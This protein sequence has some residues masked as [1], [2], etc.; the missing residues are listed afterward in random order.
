MGQVRPIGRV[1]D[2]S[3]VPPKAKML[4]RYSECSKRADKRRDRLGFGLFLK[5]VPQVLTF[6]PALCSLSVSRIVQ[7]SEH[8]A[9]HNVRYASKNPR[10]PQP[11]AMMLAQREGEGSRVGV[12]AQ[13]P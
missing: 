1:P 8:R 6:E 13:C 9:I 3:G 12:P 11:A 10:Q 7:I 5:L 4:L 2:E